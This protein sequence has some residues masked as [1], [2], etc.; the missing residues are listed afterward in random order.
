[1]QLIDIECV[2]DLVKALSVERI[3]RVQKKIMDS[4]QS[5]NALINNLKSENERLRTEFSSSLA[6]KKEKLREDLEQNKNESQ[7]TI[8]NV[9]EERDYL[10]EE[11]TLKDAENKKQKDE[12][13]KLGERIQNLSSK[14]GK[15]EKLVGE[16]QKAIKEK[17]RALERKMETIKRQQNRF[18]TLNKKRPPKSEVSLCNT[19]CTVACCVNLNFWS[20]ILIILVRIIIS[21]SLLHFFIISTRHLSRR[22]DEK[23]LYDERK[24]F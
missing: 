9:N 24:H 2:V 12:I 7:K 4:F 3:G 19:F 21:Q 14:L 6:V 1:M 10:I 13:T 22:S 11:N 23:I 17:E 5:K 18:E 8:T 15:S 16:L 20:I